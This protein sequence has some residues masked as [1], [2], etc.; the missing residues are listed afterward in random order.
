MSD[1]HSSTVLYFLCGRVEEILLKAS[2]NRD[3]LKLFLA[4]NALYWIFYIRL[5]KLLGSMDL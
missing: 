4:K 1:S 5:K 2:T 3:I